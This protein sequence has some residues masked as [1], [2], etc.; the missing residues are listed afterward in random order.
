MSDEPQKT[1]VENIPSV[2]GEISAIAS[3]GAPFL[4]FENAPFYGLLNGVGKIAITVSRQ[5][6]N[7]PSGGVLS[8][9]VLVG[10]LVGNLPAIRALR[11]ALDGILL[12]AEPPPNTPAN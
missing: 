10:H 12:M 11:A 6:A 9:Q 1:P 3:A 4:Y 5:I 7:A 2:A 8:D